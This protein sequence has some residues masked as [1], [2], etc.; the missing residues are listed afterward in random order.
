M[1]AVTVLRTGGKTGS[2]SVSYAT[3]PVTARAGVDY[4]PVSGTLTFAP[5]E[6]SKVVDVPV[7]KTG[8]PGAS[9]TFRFGLGNPTGGSTLGAVGLATVTIDHPLP[10]GAGGPSGSG[11]PSGAA[12]STVSDILPM[13]NSRGI[14]EVVITF[15]KAMDLTRA[16]N[17][18]NYDLILNGRPVPIVKAGYDPAYDH[19]VLFLGAT[20]PLGVFARLDVRGLVDTSGIPFDG[21]GTGH[22]PG[23]P[24]AALIGEGRQ[25]VYT[26]RS[27]D[28][29]NL[30][31]S[32]PGLIALRR[33]LDG[34]AQAL[35]F[36][37]TTANVSTLTGLVVPKPGTAGT[38]S[39][40]SISGAAGVKI[41][42]PT[43]PFYL[44]GIFAQALDARAVDALA[45]SDRLRAKG[46]I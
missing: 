43:P 36:L 28:S 11:G 17:A 45:V 5:G 9:P 12:P 44:G 31:L 19:T 46:G 41:K 22:S 24:Y 3:A 18:A 16:Q 8:V 39:I 25:L 33:G 6:V 15:S 2:V 10:A 20:V 29:V 1:A 34:E 37:G 30:T 32:G 14:Y 42:L 40:P 26:D 4:T 13:A 21:S 23:S 7:F 27:G 35:R 38:T